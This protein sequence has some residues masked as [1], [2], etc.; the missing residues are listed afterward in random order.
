MKRKKNPL[1]VRA[2]ELCFGLR[3]FVAYARAGVLSSA[4][5]LA[6]KNAQYPGVLGKNNFVENRLKDGYDR[7]FFRRKTSMPLYVPPDPA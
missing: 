3:V 6:S 1:L 4:L 2:F 5:V 7:G